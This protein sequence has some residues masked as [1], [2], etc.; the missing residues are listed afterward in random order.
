MIERILLIGK[1]CVDG[2]RGEGGDPFLSL[3]LSLSLFLSLS[4]DLLYD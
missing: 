2:M 1:Q 4:L 3:S